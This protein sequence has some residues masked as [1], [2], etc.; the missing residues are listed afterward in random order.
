MGMTK[1]EII[2]T[3]EIAL[4]EVEWNYHMDYAVA[5]EEAIKLIQDNS[6]HSTMQIMPKANEFINNVQ[7]Y[8][9]VQNEYGDMMVACWD[10]K[11]WT[12]MYQHEYVKDKIIAY[13]ELPNG[14]EAYTS[15]KSHCL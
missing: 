10:G 3:L 12:Q 14:Y 1:E 11:G 5:F 6:W 7:K 4:A 2:K 15:E 13:R 9:L 8:Y